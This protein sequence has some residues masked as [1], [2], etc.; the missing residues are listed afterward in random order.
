VDY[1]LVDM[2]STQE[3]LQPSCD[4]R[5]RTP[6]VDPSLP[7]RIIYVESAS[8][9]PECP[10]GSINGNVAEDCWQLDNDLNRCPINGQLVKLLRTAKEIADG[11]LA[12]GTQLHL[13]CRTCEGGFVAGC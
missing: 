4:L 5:I 8:S 3:G 6:T 13:R 1:T 11:P 10:A 7:D 2:D 12:P 9:L